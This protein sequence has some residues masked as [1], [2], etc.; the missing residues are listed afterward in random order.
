MK[1]N[2]ICHQREGTMDKV[3][4]ACLRQD[5]DGTY[6][7]WGKWGRRSAKRLSEQPKISGVSEQQA[8]GT[9]LFWWNNKLNEGYIDIDSL[10]YHDVVTRE[11]PNIAAA[12][13][14]EVDEP[15]TVPLKSRP[16]KPKPSKPIKSKDAVAVC[17]DNSGI[18]DRFDKDVEY[19]CESSG[20]PDMLWVY[21]KYGKRDEWFSERFQVV[22]DR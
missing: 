5:A 12:L 16:S 9:Q 8:R 15:V 14:Q 19:V 21:D 11:T 22:E 2:L 4:M 1:R 13:E 17:V 10:S 7:A 18:E 6:S 3:Y 20:D